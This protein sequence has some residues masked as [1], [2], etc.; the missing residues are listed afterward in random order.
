MAAIS[1]NN[2]IMFGLNSSKL[3]ASSHTQTKDPSDVIDYILDFS[4]LLQADAISTATVTGTNITI[5]SSA[6]S[7]NIVTIFVS[8]GTNCTLGTIKTT[9]VTTNS[10]PRTIERSFKVKVIDL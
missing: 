9:I 7:G 1:T 4:K 6:V 10:T 8:G 3:E 5:D 2:T